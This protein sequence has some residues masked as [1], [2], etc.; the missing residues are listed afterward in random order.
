MPDEGW[1][2]DGRKVESLLTSVLS[3]F[4]NTVVD[5][6][7]VS[8]AILGRDGDFLL[9]SVPDADSWRPT[10]P[11]LVVLLQINRNVTDVSSHDPEALKVE[12]ASLLQDFV[13][14]ESHCAWPEVQ[15][16]QVLDAALDERGQAVWHHKGV[17]VSPIGSLRY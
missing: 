12:I 6:A 1:E 14:D 4:A 10:D 9:G 7:A 5:D 3:D 15:S 11:E 17:R 16:G 13:V 2:A 8:I